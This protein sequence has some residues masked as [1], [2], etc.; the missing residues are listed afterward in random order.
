MG[1]WRALAASAIE[2][3]VSQA[4]INEM[5]QYPGS[6]AIPL[7]NIT[8]VKVD[9][10]MGGAYLSVKNNTPGLKPAYSFVLAVVLVEMTSGFMQSETPK[11][12]RLHHEVLV[13]RRHPAA[14][15]PTSIFTAKPSVYTT[16]TT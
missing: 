14:T 3:S 16:A 6:Y 10:K 8:E 12:I 2:K 9:R 4:E 1:T 13:S 11:A 15:V 7:E 5:A